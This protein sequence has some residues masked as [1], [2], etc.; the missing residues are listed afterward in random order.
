[1]SGSR[2]RR[3]TELDLETRTGEVIAPQRKHPGLPCL[4]VAYPPQLERIGEL[5]CVAV[6]PE[7]RAGGR[8]DTLLEQMER[9]A[10]HQGLE[11]LFVLTTRTAQWF[12][13]RGFAKA[14]VKALPKERQALYNYK[15]G[16]KVFVKE[17]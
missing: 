14:G 6:H 13:E 17:L 15:R 2:R 1:M 16:S 7:Y 9:I 4:T 8:G 10:R 11:R 12:E 3:P 5:A